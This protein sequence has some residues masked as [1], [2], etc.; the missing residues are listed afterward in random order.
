MVDLTWSIT[1]PQQPCCLS[2]Y[3]DLT[4]VATYSLLDSELQL[5][6]GSVLM[7]KDSE[8]VSESQYFNGG[9]MHLDWK[10]P[11]YVIC[12]DSNGNL[13]SVNSSSLTIDHTAKVSDTCLTYISTNSDRYFISDVSGTINILDSSTHQSLHSKSYN[14][15][16]IWC[17]TSQ[18]SLLL[19]PSS[20]G[21][22]SLYDTN[23]YTKSHTF[24]GL[25]T[26]DIV[27]LSIDY[28]YIYS[29]SLDGSLVC[30][31]IRN[32]A[33]VKEYQMPGGVWRHQ[34]LNSVIA[35]ACM[36]EGVA[37]VDES[38][39]IINR[40]KEGELVY[41]LDRKNEEWLGCSFYDK[42]IFSFKESE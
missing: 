42:K 14:D 26:E 21:N 10:Q 33:V 39:G 20:F 34:K 24:R 18:N 27:S 29:G 30:I 28:P 15:Y 1:I 22:L 6:Q 32:Y 17:I 37:I 7:L 25:H 40:L 31:D 3:S 35:C 2:S 9:I 36:Q 13:L 19:I 4:A 8:I 41:G 11:N 16:E 38:T 5:K 23:T 12:I